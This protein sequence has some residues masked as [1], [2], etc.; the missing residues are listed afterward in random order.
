M[1]PLASCF[2]MT[3]AYMYIDIM[4]NMIDYGFFS[5]LCRVREVLYNRTSLT[6]LATVLA[7]VLLAGEKRAYKSFFI[8]SGILQY[9]TNLYVW[10]RIRFPRFAY[11]LFPFH[12]D[13]V[14][15]Y[16]TF[17]LFLFFS[18]VLL[19]ESNF[20]SLFYRQVAPTQQKNVGDYSM[21][22]DKFNT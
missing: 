17:L 22:Q 13:G 7:P 11:Y 16:K 10:D 12:F 18:S 6:L 19:T 3:Y 14:Y 15:L 9:L 5:L 1:L 2:G 20:L 21:V 4:L 8:K